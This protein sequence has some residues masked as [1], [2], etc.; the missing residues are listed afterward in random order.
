MEALLIQFEN[1]IRFYN[2][3]LSATVRRSQA[4]RQIVAMGLKALPLI[5]KRLED[6]KPNPEGDVSCGWAALMSEIGVVYDLGS[7]KDWLFGD[8][9]T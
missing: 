9:S 4:A 3:T 5:V 2:H 6:S 8:I 1:D 7:S